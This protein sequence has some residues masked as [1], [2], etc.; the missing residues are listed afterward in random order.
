VNFAEV[1]EF[2]RANLPPAP[3]R[4]LEVGA[5]EGELARS[6]AASG[7]DVTAIDPRSEAS[8]V[9]PVALLELAAEP[10]DGAVAVVSLHHVEPL[11]ES[12]GRLASLLAPGA[13][14]VIDEFDIGRLD[15]A[16]ASWWLERRAAR[17]EAE[18]ESPAELIATMRT[19][20][21]SL[22]RLQA[23]LEPWFELGAA[24]HGTYLYRWKLDESV[25]PAE[26]ALIARGALPRTGIRFIATRRVR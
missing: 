13:P 4:V 23:A 2:V 20:V 3:A 8:N 11:E 1:E 17:G 5:G 15:E 24:V 22:E 16:A 10:F 26:E 12:C 7:Y 21:H 19:K 25:R 6:L 18:G 14:L 9:R